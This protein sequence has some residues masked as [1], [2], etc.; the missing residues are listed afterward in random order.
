M[1]VWPFI[2]AEEA[3]QH[4][5]KRA[6]E[7]LEV[8]RAAFYEYRKHTPSQRELSDRELLEQIRE[9]HR[10]SKGTYG[11]PRVHGELRNQ[12]IHVGRKRVARRR[13][14][15]RQSGRRHRASGICRFMCSGAAP[16]QR[17]RGDHP[18]R[19]HS[20]AGIQRGFGSGVCG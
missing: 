5:V 18:A 10:V 15:P 12:G 20:G 7:L 3:G 11:S 19:Q 14:G 4:S 6:C 1:N 9:I 16:R 13:I 8:S 2:E 17:R